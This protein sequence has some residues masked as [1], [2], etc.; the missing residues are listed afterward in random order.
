MAKHRHKVILAAFIVVQDG[1]QILLQR[2][3]NT[4]FR[5]GEYE[6]STGHVEAG[7]TPQFAASR[8]LQEETNLVVEPEALQLF[9]VVTNDFETEGKP[10]TYLFFK[11]PITACEG[12]FKIME[13]EKC[14]DMRMFRTS[15]LPELVPHVAIALK[16]LDAEG[17]TFSNMDSLFA[18]S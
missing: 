5:D 10:Y 16:S 14:D 17:V 1:D 8:E 2:R 12:A 13:T 15:E 18:R 3:Y 6:V 9:H 7:E 4:G 11:V